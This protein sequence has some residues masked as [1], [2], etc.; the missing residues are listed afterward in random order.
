M[1]VAVARRTHDAVGEDH[2][3]VLGRHDRP[4]GAESHRY[5]GVLVGHA[6]ISWGSA[7]TAP[8]PPSRR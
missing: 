6:A 4:P 1:I 8:E 2:W 3:V 5:E 7:K